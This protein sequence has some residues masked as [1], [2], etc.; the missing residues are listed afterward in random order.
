MALDSGPTDAMLAA[1]RRAPMPPAPSPRHRPGSD[2]PAAAQAETSGWSGC[3]RN[4]RTNRRQ[5]AGAGR[6]PGPDPYL[7]NDRY[8]AKV[9]RRAGR[10]PAVDG[11]PGVEQ[12]A[13]PFPQLPRLRRRDRH[14]LPA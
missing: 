6:H 5:M 2:Q 11:L 3:A 14:D 10:L 7:L 9:E 12:L 8:H 4:P 1:A 13:E